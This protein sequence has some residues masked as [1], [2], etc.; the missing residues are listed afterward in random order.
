MLALS[1]ELEGVGREGLQVLQ[2]VGSCR[3]KTQFLLKRDITEYR[4][5]SNER[6]YSLVRYKILN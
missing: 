6:V 4:I 5:E 1:S 3:L 2:K